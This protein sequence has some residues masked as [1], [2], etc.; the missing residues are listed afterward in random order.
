MT[1]I[2][3][4]SGVVKLPVVT[5]AGWDI[6]QIRDIV[7][8]DGRGRVAGFSLAGRGLFAGPLKTALPWGG[9]VGLGPDAVIVRD[10]DALVPAGEVYARARSESGGGRG[11]VVGAQVL[12]EAGSA[13]GTVTDVVLRIPDGGREPAEVVG[14]AIGAPGRNP[15]GTLTQFLP[16]PQSMATSGE[17]LI[18][19]EDA[20][21]RLTGDL[22]GFAAQVRADHGDDPGGGEPGGDEPG[23]DD[24]AGT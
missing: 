7:Y 19:P 21:D 3:L 11:N 5:F 6:A 17:H 2:A 20:R 16:M 14:Y 4:A 22:A 18:V 24:G 23:G 13:L 8:A 12:T 15:R 9:V 10:E 1:R